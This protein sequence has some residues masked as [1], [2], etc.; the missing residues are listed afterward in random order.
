MNRKTLYIWLLIF[1]PV[2]G[3]ANETQIDLMKMTLEELMNVEVIT[4]SREEQRLDESPEPV[5]G[6]LLEDTRH[7]GAPTIS[8]VPNPVSSARM[9]PIGVCKWPVVSRD[10][11]GYFAD[12]SP[13]S[14]DGWNAYTLPLFG[15][16]CEVGFAFLNPGIKMLA[17]GM[18]AVDQTGLSRR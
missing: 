11:N 16:S 6:R 9:A 14:I 4:V 1:A 10:S 7:P 12:E 17:V 3:R 18:A 5:S 13:I 2:V 15:M 8:A